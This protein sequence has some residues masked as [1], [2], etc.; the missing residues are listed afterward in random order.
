MSQLA[1]VSDILP[2][3]I[4]PN[5][6]II[7]LP[8]TSDIILNNINYRIATVPVCKEKYGDGKLIS[9]LCIKGDIFFLKDEFPRPEYEL[10]EVESCEQ[11]PL[12]PSASPP[13]SPPPTPPPPPPEPSRDEIK[14]MIKET[15]RDKELLKELIRVLLA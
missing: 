2:L 8:A 3:G 15:L 1:H 14:K 10:S 11:C 4:G 13:P 6:N 7:Y 5:K 12:F 9:R